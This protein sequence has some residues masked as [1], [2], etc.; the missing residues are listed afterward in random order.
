MFNIDETVFND[1]DNWKGKITIPKSILQIDGFVGFTSYYT[2][3]P[4]A[5]RKISY[6]VDVISGSNT[7]TIHFENTL[8]RPMIKVVKSTPENILISKMSPAI[9]PFSVNL[10]VVGTAAIHNLSYFLDLVTH[11]KLTVNI[12]TS[13]KIAFQRNHIEE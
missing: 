3:I 4:N 6:E 11:D 2:A 10:K 9:A 13:K 5:E 7:Q 1:R 12:T 8:T